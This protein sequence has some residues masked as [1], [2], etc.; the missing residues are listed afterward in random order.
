MFKE[1]PEHETEEFP[2]V[3]ITQTDSETEYPSMDAN[4]RIDN[5]YSYMIT[6]LSK[7][8]N[9]IYIRDSLTDEIKTILSDTSKE[10]ED[11]VSMKEAGVLVKRITSSPN[12]IY[13]SDGNVLRI[14]DLVVTVRYIFG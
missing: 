5:D 2:Y 3:V 10:D 14:K 13:T 11:G 12:D 1:P 8:E 4:L 9:A 6:V 7:G